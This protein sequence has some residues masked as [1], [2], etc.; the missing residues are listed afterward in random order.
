MNGPMLI[1]LD[2]NLPGIGGL[3][4]LERLRADES[5]RD[6]PVIV[7]SGHATVHDAVAAIKLGANDFFEK[8]LTR[9][10]VLVSKQLMY[11]ER[12]AKE[13]APP[14]NM[15]R[16]LFLVQNVFPEAVAAAVEEGKV[17]A[18]R[19]LAEAAS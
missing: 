16:D 12:Y 3:E 4:A 15:A 9:E 14:Y 19:Y 6:L 13:L 17:L 1:L 2:L 18:R 11:F 8:P 5:T 7:I 10:R